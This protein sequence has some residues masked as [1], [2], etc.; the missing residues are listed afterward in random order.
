MMHTQTNDNTTN[1]NDPNKTPEKMTLTALE[2]TKL[3]VAFQERDTQTL[4]ATD[5]PYSLQFSRRHHTRGWPCHTT[6]FLRTQ[7]CLDFPLGLFTDGAACTNI[8][9]QAL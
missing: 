7:F 2:K 8:Y 9:P 6:P 3:W 1:A 4:K 5:L